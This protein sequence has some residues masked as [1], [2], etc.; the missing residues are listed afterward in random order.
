MKAKAPPRKYNSKDKHDFLETGYEGRRSKFEGVTQHDFTIFFK[1]T[2]AGKKPTE[3]RRHGS[4]D[5][6]LAYQPPT[7]STF[8]SEQTDQ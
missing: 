8:L 2:A 5:I 6:F 3:T 1:A 4:T 7:S